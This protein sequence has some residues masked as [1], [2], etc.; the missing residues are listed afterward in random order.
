MVSVKWSI[1]R[2]FF[3]SSSILPALGR[4]FVV[5]MALLTPCLEIIFKREKVRQLMQPALL[6]IINLYHLSQQMV[7]RW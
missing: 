7:N 4:I 5:R 3:N 6:L 2:D 1:Q